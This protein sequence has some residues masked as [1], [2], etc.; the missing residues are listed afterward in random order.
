MSS[1]KVARREFLKTGSAAAIGLSAMV[2]AESLFAAAPTDRMIMPLLGVGYAP[3]VP[4]AGHSVRLAAAGKALSGDPSFISRGARVTIHSFAR[5]RRHK[6][7]AGGAAIDVI[8]PAL[9]YTP[10]KYPRFRA[11]AYSTDK[12]AVENDGGP[13]GFTVPVTATQGLQFVIRRVP[14]ETDETPV[15]MPLALTLGSETGA[16]KLQRGVYVIA[17]RESFGDSVPP[18]SAHSV[19]LRNGQYVVDA[20][21][22]SYAVMLIDYAK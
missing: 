12:N 8:H 6:A 14:G 1:R 7:L 22:F 17:F 11:W 4:E 16:L 2:S 15:E 5:M 10:E 19:S 13:I 20:T 21:A 18:W 9:S 3:E